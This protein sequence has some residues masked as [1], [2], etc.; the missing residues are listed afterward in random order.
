MSSSQG[1]ASAGA[2]CAVKHGSKPG[3]HMAQNSAGPEGTGVLAP[4]ASPATKWVEV[5]SAGIN[6]EDGVARF[7][8]DRLSSPK[9]GAGGLD[10]RWQFKLRHS[11]KKYYPLP[12]ADW[13]VLCR[14]APHYLISACITLNCG[15]CAER[16]HSKATISVVTNSAPL[17]ASRS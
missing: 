14:L 9:T 3:L 6:M 8:V 10:A 7:G 2:G 1:C 16:S 12:S 15:C 17:P 4:P 5:R 11:R 13:T